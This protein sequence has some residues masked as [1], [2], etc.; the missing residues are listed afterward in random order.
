MAAPAALAAIDVS[1]QGMD[2]IMWIMKPSNL[3]G[4]STAR[5]KI[6]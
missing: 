1:A 6:E 2:Q 4:I 3:V 5:L